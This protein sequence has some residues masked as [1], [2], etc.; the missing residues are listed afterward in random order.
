DA[1]IEASNGSE[2]IRL[3]LEARPDII[4]TDMRMPRMDGVTMAKRVRESLPDSAIIFMS[5]Y[6]DKEY[7]KAAID[8]KAVSYVEKPLDTAEVS[9]AIKKAS[10]ELYARGLVKRGLSASQKENETRLAELMTRPASSGFPGDIPLPEG[11]HA[12]DS[13]TCMILKFAGSPPESGGEPSGLMKRKKLHEIHIIK[14]NNCLCYFIYGARLE[15]DV[16]LKLSSEIR[17][18]CSGS[19][20]SCIA[21]GDSIHG[22]KHAYDSY[23]SAVV[24]LVDAFFHEPVAILENSDDLSATPPI[25]KDM[26]PAYTEALE[27]GDSARTEA[28][29]HEISKQFS[30]PCRL[31]PSQVK[32]IYYQLFLVLQKAVRHAQMSEMILKEGQSIWDTVEQAESLSSLHG[33]LAKLTDEYIKGL[34]TRGTEG[35]MVYTIKEFIRQNYRNESLSIKSVSDHVNRSA[36]YVCTLFKTETGLTLNQ[37]ITGYRIEK[38]QELLSDP[39]YK[40]TDVASRVGYNDVNYFGKIFKKVT[41]FSPSEFRSNLSGD[42]VKTTGAT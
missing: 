40:I 12:D 18:I 39:R 29:L 22:M 4:L 36:P 32:D 3:A 35:S 14:E 5:G 25:I 2:G 7:L 37:Y 19:G 13:F 17:D 27:T 28:V 6:S 42:G 21:L 16:L 26:A 23:A 38:A 20:L 15:R 30:P 9:D 31:L 10:E 33:E 11:M 1:V 34:S 24:L 41:N 8:L